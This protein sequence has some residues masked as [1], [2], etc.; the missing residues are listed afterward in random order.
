V[1][2]AVLVWAMYTSEMTSNSR[3]SGSASKATC[4]RPPSHREPPSSLHLRPA[5]GHDLGDLDPVVL[6]RGDILAGAQEILTVLGQA[7]HG[8]PSGVLER[9]PAVGHDLGDPHPVVD[10]LARVVQG[11]GPRHHRRRAQA[12]PGE[13]AHPRIGGQQPD[14]EGRET[15]QVERGDQR[16]LATDPVRKMTEYRG[17]DGLARNATPNDAKD[18][19]VATA[20]SRLGRTTSRRPVR[21]PGRRERS[22]TTPACS[23]PSLRARSCDICP[24][25]RFG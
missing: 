17:P 5:L 18:R 21:K 4:A 20:G 23:R 1:T 2:D 19:S 7:F 13:H 12:G 9:W 15:H 25:G 10:F 3:R 22:R 6:L 14:P 24:R 16:S 8:A 11:S